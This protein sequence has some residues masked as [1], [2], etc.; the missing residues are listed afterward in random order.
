MKPMILILIAFGTVLSFGAVQVFPDGADF[1]PFEC[2][3]PENPTVPTS[4]EQRLELERRAAYRIV[5]PAYLTAL[6]GEP[7]IELLMPVA[8]VRVAQVADTWGAPRG[9]GRL[10]EGQDI[11][12]PAGTE[13]YS[14][15]EGYVYRI[16]YAPLGGNVVTVV[17][18]GGVRYYY[19]HL[20]TFAE[21]LREGQFVTP[22]TLL[23]YV[24]NTGNARTTPPHLH[25]G[26]YSG[27]VASCRWTAIDP[28]PL[29]VNR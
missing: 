16:G 2:P 21:E 29:M 24:G 18:R 20:Q 26:L 14:A 22:E 19:A 12:A 9:G 8:G 4:E 28:L 13:I 25:F 15:T 17:G 6:P 7:D 3:A 1:V 23:G 11:F 5:L 10:H 27:D